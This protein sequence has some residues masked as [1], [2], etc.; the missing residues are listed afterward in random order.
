MSDDEGR[1]LQVLRDQE[2]AIGR[3]DAEA[4]ISALADD[5]VTYDLPPP[6][7][8]RGAGTPAVEGLP[9]WFTTW[10]DGVTVE[11]KDPQVVK[12]GDLA[13]VF[14]LA[15]MRGIK[16]D[17]GSLDQWHR[18]TI[19]LRRRDGIWKISHEHSSFP[20]RMDGSGIAATDL[21]L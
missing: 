17:V 13:V 5:V 19:V 11:L 18:R 7:E 20:M 9:E 6:L 14:G 12:D 2:T 15:R 21:V 10:Q 16:K 8:Y 3:G 1:I 4:A